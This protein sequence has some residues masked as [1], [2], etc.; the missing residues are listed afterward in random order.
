MI[1]NASEVHA[2]LERILVT[3]WL[4]ESHQLSALLRHIVEETLEGR[5]DGL[6]EYPLGREVFHRPPDYDPRIDAIVRVQASLLRKRLALYYEHEGRDSKFRIDLPRGGYVPEFREVDP[7]EN[8]APA[9]FDQA[10]AARPVRRWPAFVA[11]LMTGLVLAVG[12]GLWLPSRS[13][14]TPAESRA[15]WGAYLQPGVETVATL[16]VP[17]FFS[18]GDGLFVRDTQI[19]KLTDDPARITRVGEILGRGFRPQEDVYTGIGDAIGTH[20]VARWLEQHGVMASVGNSNYIGPSDVEGKNLVVVA[21]ARFQTLL[22]PMELPDRFPFIATGF[23]GGYTVPDPLPGELPHYRPKG[24]AGVNTSYAV[25]SLWPG[26]PPER[27]MMYLSGIE[28][29]S[30]QGAAQYVLDPE[31]LIDLQGRLDADPPDG[32]RGRRS[33]FFQVLLRVEGKNNRVR[34]ANYVTHRYLPDKR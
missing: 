10:P 3:R 11:G 22:Q 6:K 30:T 21:S 4:R 16:G 34:S 23:G 25:V 1:S 8:P 32:L 24:G 18:G 9:V 29:W 19:N 27:R 7:V 15:L 2:E 12:A 33:P 14:V 20:Q 5:T 17:L 31:K 28:T 26:T 13:R